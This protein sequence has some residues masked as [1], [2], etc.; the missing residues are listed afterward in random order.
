MIRLFSRLLTLTAL[1]LIV[2]AV[3]AQKGAVKRAGKQMDSYSFIDAR[4]IYLKVVEEGYTS[5]QIYKKLG[6]T[7]YYNSQYPDAAKWYEKLLSEFPEEVGSVEYYFKAAQSVKS[8]GKYERSDALMEMYRANG[9]NPSVVDQYT[10]HQDYLE[11]IARGALNLQLSGADINSEG[12]DFVGSWMGDDLVFAS[13]NNATGEKTY[14]WTNEGFLDLFMASVDENGK[15]SGVVALPGEVN[16]PFHESSTTFSEDGKTMYF[17]RNNYIDGKKYRGKGKVVGLKIY[18][19]T[20][21]ADNSWTNIEELPFNSDDYSTAHPALSPDGKRL[22]FS[23]NMPGTTGDDDKSDL[24]FVEIN[25]DGT[26]GSPVNMGKPINTAHRE[27]FP[28]IS[29]ENKLYFASDG[30]VGLGGF[31][32]FVYDLNDPSAE[33]VN[34]G[35]PVN[36]SLDDF[37][38]I[39]DKERMFGYVSSNREGGMGSISD[40]IYLLKKCV[41]T[42]AGT[43]TNIT[44]GEVI[45]NATVTLLDADNKELAT[46]TSDVNGRYVFDVPLD[47]GMVYAVRARSEGCDTIEKRV[48]TPDD[49]TQMEVPMGLPCDPCPPD[50]LG[51]RLSLEP[52]YF[53]FDRFNIRPDAEI[54]L[55]KILAAMREYPQLKIH[56]ESHTDSRG[57]DAYNEALSEKRAQSTLEWLVDNGID[58]SRLTA[59]G[60]GE[61][62]LVNRCSNGVECT[63]EEHQLNRRSMFIIQE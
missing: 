8:L 54:E 62:Q 15:L 39:Y 35:Q 45:P 21:S 41:V 14:E 22:Y 12:S 56:I 44:S 28:Y 48:E 26:F 31:D 57:N 59:K 9:G 11:R 6:D 49:S 52:I 16:S 53:D 17:T 29:K 5:A 18:K 61:Y 30:H 36:S 37:G 20:K 13:T 58:R 40:D 7:Y 33:I 51:C 2:P 38:F 27:S 24:W 55:A 46:A 60:Y 50:D 32:I 47:C 34:L 42:I 63:E 19:A 25:A 3:T 23:S 1:L 4:D 10:G 43:V